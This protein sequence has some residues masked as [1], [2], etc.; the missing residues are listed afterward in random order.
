MAALNGPGTAVALQQ[1]GD[2]GK[3]RNE[4][5]GPPGTT[6]GATQGAGDGTADNLPDGWV[7]R[8]DPAGFSLA[9]PGGNWKRQVFDANQTDYT[10]DGG[11]HLIRI[12]VDDSPDFDD[13]YLHQV[14][15]DQQLSQRLAEYERL[16]LEVN[17][18]R[19]RRGSLWEYTWTA[20]AKDTEWPGPYR[21]IEETYIARDGVEYALYIAGPA[22][23]WATTRKQFDT[24][25]RSWRP[26]GQ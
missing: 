8:T 22:K 20:L 11:K 21:A 26:R 19:D 18:Y 3:P 17:T 4:A 12:A 15:L 24:V 16:T 5:S 2:E 7:R 6:P 1:W 13:P 10:P 23:D 14:D 25:L 9:V